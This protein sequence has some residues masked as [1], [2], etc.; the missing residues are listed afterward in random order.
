MDSYVQIGVAVL[1]DRTTGEP[2]Q[3]RIPLYA[4]SKAAPQASG[5]TRGEEKILS[6]I[7]GVF[8]DVFRK[9]SDEIRKIKFMEE[10]PK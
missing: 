7:A 1:R 2:L 8:V 5:L 4:K 10:T 3:Q 6:D 9:Y